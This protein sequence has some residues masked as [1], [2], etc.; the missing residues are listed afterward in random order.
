MIDLMTIVEEEAYHEF[1]HHEGSVKPIWCLLTD[2]GLD[3]NPQFLANILKY[4]LIFKKL[5]LDYL[6]VRTHASGQSAYNPVERSMSSL[7][8]KLAGIVLNAFN[9]GNHLG[10]VNGQVSIVDEELGYRNFK[11]AGEHLCEFW[12]HDLINKRPVV[13]TYIEKHNDI[14]FSDIEEGTWDWINRHS[15]ICK[16]SFDL[17][18]CDD[19]SCCEPPRATNAFELLSLN[20]GFLPPIIQGQDKHFLNLIHTLEFFN[21]QLP[22]YDE[23]C[24]SIPSELYHELVCR[25]CGKYFPTKAF[26]KMHIKNM[27]P[28]E[29]RKMRKIDNNIQS[30][31]KNELA[32]HIEGP[33][34]LDQSINHKDNKIT[35]I[36]MHKQRRD[37][38]KAKN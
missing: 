19:R 26:I 2:G 1:T 27:H 30:D 18:K 29:R 24:P 12:N 10:N 35:A 22:D 31:T 21:D 6:T 4:M 5:K 32:D 9:Y 38:D 34:C 15:Q 3:E 23:H 17:R 25:K 28:S 14:I 36:Q 8:G 7:S 13:A 37:K 33:R 11:H 16:Y 20:N